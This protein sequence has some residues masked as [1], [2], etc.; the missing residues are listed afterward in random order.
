MATRAEWFR[1]VDASRVPPE[2]RLAAHLMLDYASRDLGLEGLQIVWVKPT[3]PTFGKL[4]R[5]LAEMAGTRPD[6][7]EAEPFTGLSRTFT[8]DRIW[9]RADL[10]PRETALAVAHEARHV[11]QFTH[12][13]PPLTPQELEVAERDATEYERRAY[14]AVFGE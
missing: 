6:S 10:P 3:D 2:A 8:C 11:W 1:E 9:V 12:Y 14:R 5:L 4:E 7:F 13:R